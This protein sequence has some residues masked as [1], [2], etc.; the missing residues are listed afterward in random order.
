MDG[1]DKALESI[2]VLCF[3]AASCGFRKGSF[4]ITNGV[5]ESEME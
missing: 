5:D 4:E 1:V 3:G 2:A